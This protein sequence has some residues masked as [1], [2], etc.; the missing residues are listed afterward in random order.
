MKSLKEISW[1]VTEPEY[2]ADDALSYSTLAKFAREGFDK[3]GSLFDKVETPSLTFGSAVDA[4]ITGGQE[5]FDK[6][7]LVAN[8]PAIKDSVE[9][10][11]KSLF[12][13]YGTTCRTIN[14][15][16]E[17]DI[18]TATEVNGFQLNWKPETRAKVIKEQGFEYYNLMFL[19][20]DKKIISEELKQKVDSAVEALRTSEATKFYFEPNNPFNKDIE[21]FYQLKFKAN[22]NGIDFRCMAD[23]IVVDHQ[24]KVIHPVDL[25]T[26]SHTEWEFYKSFAQWRYDIQSRLYWRIIR[27]NMDKDEVYKYYELSDYTFIVVNKETLT[28]LKWVY[29]GTKKEGTLVYGNNFKCQDPVEIAQELK[30]YLEQNPSV[31]IGIDKAG[32]NY[33]EMYLNQE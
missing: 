7:F 4:L 8:F 32:A 6:N 2:R 25:K 28:P 5:E 12:A 18:I 16:K 33:I 17:A 19:A 24:N 23:E 11:V 31:P 21:R 20:K 1:Q 3:L 10:V 15:I 13:S 30:Y 14:D 27:A 22:I 29:G 26:S 9:K